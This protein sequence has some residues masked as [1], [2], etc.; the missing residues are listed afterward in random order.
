MLRERCTG[1]MLGWEGGDGGGGVDFTKKWAQKFATRP[2]TLVVQIHL[3]ESG[4]RHE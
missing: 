3:G 4:V 2:K 1:C